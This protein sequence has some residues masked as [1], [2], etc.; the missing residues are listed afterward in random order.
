[1][2]Y[3]IGRLTVTLGKDKVRFTNDIC[4]DCGHPIPS[5]WPIRWDYAG[6]TRHYLCGVRHARASKGDHKGGETS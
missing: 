6:G 2:K 1:M 4:A 5:W 3:R